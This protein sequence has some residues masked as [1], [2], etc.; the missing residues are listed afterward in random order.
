MKKFYNYNFNNKWNFYIVLKSAPS[1]VL[2]KVQ[3]EICMFFSTLTAAAQAEA[4]EHKIQPPVE[5]KSNTHTINYSVNTPV[6]E[7][8]V[9]LM[10]EKDF[11]RFV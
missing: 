4:P 10:S 7:L 1:G 2:F 9:T 3:V 6:W 8:I 11:W 5:G